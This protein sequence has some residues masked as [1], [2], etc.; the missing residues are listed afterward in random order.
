MSFPQKKDAQ[1]LSRDRNA[2]QMQ[3]RLFDPESRYYLHMSGQGLAKGSTWAWRGHRYQAHALRC[4]ALTAGE[5]WPFVTIPADEI[6]TS[7][8]LD[9]LAADG[10]IQ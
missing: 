1:R 2:A 9:V 7:I 4:R 8:D 10:A 6:P 5:D 3:V